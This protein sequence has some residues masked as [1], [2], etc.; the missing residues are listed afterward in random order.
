LVLGSDFVS[1]R[2]M[3]SSSKSHTIAFDAAAV[4]AAVAACDTAAATAATAATAA[5]AALHRR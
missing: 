3:S 4:A 1:R 5:A 2:F